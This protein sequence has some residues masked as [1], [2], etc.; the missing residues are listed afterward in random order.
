MAA[1]KQRSRMMTGYLRA[2]SVVRLICWLLVSLAGHAVAENQAWKINLKNADIREFI[3]QISTITNKNFIVDPK[4][5]GE[6]TVISSTPLGADA[7]YEL[8]LSVLTVH[9][10]AALPGA[11][12]VKIV[13]QNRARQM[14]SDL[15]ADGL[16]PSNSEVIITRV[17]Q[18]ENIAALEILKTLRPLASQYG[19]VVA[20]KVSNVIIISDHARNVSRL[21]DLIKR[22]DIVDS[23]EVQLV[24]L[25]HIWVNDL[26]SLLETL[27]PEQ[28]GKSAA[29][30]TRVRIVAN[31]RTNTL[32]LRGKRSALLRMREIIDELDIPAR[33]S[34][35][36]EVIR[37]AHSDAA[38]MA[39]LLDSM[40]SAG[41]AGDKSPFADTRIEA[42]EGLNA[43]VIRATPDVLSE[44]KSIIAELDVR[45]VQV[46]IEAAIVE[47]TTN[48][49]RQLG[50][51]LAIADR[52]GS[53][54]PVA[55]TAPS[56]TLVQILQG[57]ANN[58]GGLP[59]G[60]TP[61]FGTGRTSDDGVNFA[62]LLRA[63]AENRDANLLSTPSIL[64]LDNEEA[65]I[66]VG[67]NVPFRTGSTVTGS[68]GATNP[69]TTIQR[70]D[71]GVTL[72]VTPQ[73]QDDNLVRLTVS[74][75]V[76][77][78]DQGNI[79][80]GTQGASDLIT[81]KRTINTTVLAD[82]GE[83]VILGGLIRDNVM[84]RTTKVPL[85]GDIPVLGRLFRNNSRT[86]EKRN[87]LV[88]LRPTILAN[89]EET[90]EAS[91]RK[92]NSVRELV[93]EGVSTEDALQQL[94]DGVAP[95]PGG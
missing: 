62:F 67:Q 76:S 11:T 3:T 54:L 44:L 43:L 29:G 63:L 60:N 35:T 87:L 38:T 40:T 92:Y 52:S 73:I 4:V 33:R 41:S 1:D 51:E 91:K 31:E 74:Q 18:I 17:V 24:A 56:G 23:N 72:Q 80:I 69:F 94:L 19:H 10:Y 85:V 36:T 59:S 49:D 14:G 8:L 34:N 30:P 90:A 88:F 65:K 71:V 95:R 22:I 7:S 83:V 75:E 42:D 53:A 77:E 86:M 15:A 6:V 26:V 39:E 48:F 93:I 13:Q 64:T 57:I 58:D 20:V 25:E 5:Q 79:G 82:D 45:R 46:L 2:P 16:R 66:T 81:Q 50:A 27:A 68:D 37:L 12:G 89:K 84:T 78:V 61:V 28:L 9:G 21:T 32:V 55:I 47:V 70:Q